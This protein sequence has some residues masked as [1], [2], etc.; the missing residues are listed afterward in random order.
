MAANRDPFFL[1]NTPTN[2][3]GASGVL[4]SFQVAQYEQPIYFQITGL[5][6]EGTSGTGSWN[7]T[8]QSLPGYYGIQVNQNSDG[9]YE[10]IP[11]GNWAMWCSNDSPPTTAS[12]PT[13]L[14]YELAGNVN[15]PTDGSVI[16][17]VA[18]RQTVANTTVAFDI[19]D[20]SEE[21]EFLYPTSGSVEPINIG[22]GLYFDSDSN[23]AVDV[24]ALID[25][26]G[27]LYINTD[28]DCSTG[29][30]PVI[31]LATSCGLKTEYDPG[32]DQTQLMV[33]FDNLVD[34]CGPLFVEECTVTID[35]SG[36][37]DPDVAGGCKVI[38]LATVC[39]LFVDDCYNLAVDVSGMLDPDGPLYVIST[40]GTDCDCDSPAYGTSACC[41]QISMAI[42]CGLQVLPGL[43]GQNELLVDLDQLITTGT[44]LY[45]VHPSAGCDYLDVGLGCGVRLDEDDLITLDLADLC[46]PSGPI[47][48]TSGCAIGLQIGCGL[49]DIGG[50]L[51]VDTSSLIVAG[52]PLFINTSGSCPQIDIT[53]PLNGIANINYNM[54]YSGTG[55]SL[56]AGGGW[57]VLN[58][59]PQTL[60]KTGNYLITCICNFFIF[61]DSSLEQVYCE[62]GISLNSSSLDSTASQA[63]FQVSNPTASTTYYCQVTL[64]RFLTVDGSPVTFYFLANPNAAGISQ[65]FA[66]QTQLT[67]VYLA[68]T[69]A[70]TPW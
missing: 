34:P 9:T 41:P 45:V 39:P 58:N 62:A 52:G 36:C 22:C 42:G 8:S 5:A 59:S 66:Q 21:W 38:K 12:S 57:Q 69:K 44:P 27:P 23:I 26:C 35:S 65:I 64:Q 50:V 48:N 11:D 40:T 33:D 68:G 55:Q 1:Q 60:T 18:P 61:T 30:C 17:R 54:P 43:D 29:S 53:P 16:V 56:G 14:L 32:T 37:C 51:E 19:E 13:G 7:F 49:N 6:T 24:S 31:N 15:V 3:G 4:G 63:I 70:L 10:Q 20:R 2:S 67:G 47:I 46:D 28:G 25:T